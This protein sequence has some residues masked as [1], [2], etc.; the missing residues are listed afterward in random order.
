MMVED[1]VGEDLQQSSRSMKLLEQPSLS[2]KDVHTW[3]D[4][5]TCDLYGKAISSS[6]T[7]HPAQHQLMQNKL[8]GE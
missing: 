6:S 7:T 5:D 4:Y 2:S 3:L 8:Y 1:L